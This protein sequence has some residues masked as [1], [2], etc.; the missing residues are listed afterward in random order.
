[1]RI[2]KT[3]SF[4]KHAVAEGLTD[5]ALKKAIAE[6]E[7]GLV[8]ALLGGNLIKKR[9]AVGSRGKSGGLR[10]IMA[11]KSADGI[12][13]CLYV[14]AKNEKENID[15]RELEALKLFGKTLFA[16]GD[17]ERQKAIAVCD[18]FEVK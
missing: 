8:N 10:T 17:T 3:K 4:A 7:Q 9:V 15:D 1:M 12:I 14:F 13:F 5:D 6:V 2:F 16:M 11:Y 18:L